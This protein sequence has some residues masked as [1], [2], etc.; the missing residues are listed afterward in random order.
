MD[1]TGKGYYI[2][3]C[4]EP[5][6]YTYKYGFL[7]KIC[8]RHICKPYSRTF[9]TIEEARAWR[10]S[11]LLRIGAGEEP[12]KYVREKKTYGET[13]VDAFIYHSSSGMY[14]VKLQPNNEIGQVNKSKS[15]PTLVT[16]QEWRDSEYKL[17]KELQERR[18]NRNKGA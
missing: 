12:D 15:F 1:V 16:A 8:K 4:L 17:L 13:R 18:N 9:K 6:I 7:A 2:F 5:H 10:T 14:R 3:K 11:E